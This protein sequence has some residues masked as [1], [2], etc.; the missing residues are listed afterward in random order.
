M[1]KYWDGHTNIWWLSIILV[2]M[3]VRG[4]FH[5]I[6]QP[7]RFWVHNNCIHHFQDGACTI[8]LTLYFFELCYF[9]KCFDI[10][11]FSFACNNDTGNNDT[12]PGD[13]WSPYEKYPIVEIQFFLGGEIAFV[14]FCVE[15]IMQFL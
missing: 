9:Q 2:H 3:Q 5:I 1:P 13:D 6:T 11:F 7:A 12:G 4:N 8:S 10:V 15:E 14:L